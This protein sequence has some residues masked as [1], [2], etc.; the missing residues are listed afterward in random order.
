MKKAER[1]SHSRLVALKSSNKWLSL[2]AVNVGNFAPPLDTGIM[3]LVLPTISLSLRA[4][5]SVV[6]WIPLTSLLIEAA[7]MPIFGRFSD[8][9]GRKR[10]FNVGLVL[11]AA[12]SF[13]AGNSLTIFELLIYRVVQSFGAAFIL[14]NGRALIADAFE[15]RERGFA[16]GTHISTIYIAMTVGTAIAGSVITVTQLVGW[17]YVFYMSGAIALVDLP[18]S[19][20]FLRES[21]KNT[22]IRIDWLGGI[23]FALAL[24]STLVYLSES[25]QTAFGSIDIYLQEFRVP[26]LNLYFYPNFLIS[27]PLS[28]VAGVAIAA[29]ILFTIREKTFSSPVIDFGL[30]RRNRMFSSTNFSALFAYIAHWSTL[31]VLSFYLQIKLY[32]PITSALILTVEPLTVTVFA[33]LGGWIASR[34]GSRDP[35]TAG[36]AIMSAALLLFT[37]LTV[38]SSLAYLVFLLAMLGAGVGVFFPSNTNAN[39]SSVDPGDRAMANGVLGM[40]RHT[41]QSVSLAISS[42]LI[43]YT[44]LGA[45]LLQGCTFSPDQYL[46]VLHL[47]FV[48]GAIFGVLGI[49]L[50]LLGKEPASSSDVGPA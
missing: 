39:L 10:Y 18:L 47:N 37:T 46:S 41:G 14:S 27:I 24:G 25:T 42:I 16:L 15:G 8:A 35:S 26:I 21:A 1:R 5:V 17:R 48:L 7:F 20:V 19:F 36:L 22:K 2:A 44:A 23:L 50:A 9:R 30:F 43:G 11:F 40:M 4:P 32:T 31:I 29:V 6:L 28:L 34:T 13:L 45:C 3:S 12:G 33:A 38:E 49:L